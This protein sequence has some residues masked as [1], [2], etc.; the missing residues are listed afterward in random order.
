MAVEQRVIKHK[1]DNALVE[2]KDTETGA[3]NRAWFPSKAVKD[4]EVKNLEHGHPYG[5]HLEEG[6]KKA[7]PKPADIVEVL[8]KMDIWTFEEAAQNANLVLQAFAQAYGDAVTAL[9]VYHISGEKEKQNAN[10]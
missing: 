5:D 3:V 8:H 4:G 6:F 9:L 1:E 2:W 7:M 10:S